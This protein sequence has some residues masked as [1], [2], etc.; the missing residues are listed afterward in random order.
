VTAL[1]FRKIPA[2][3]DPVEE[4]ESPQDGFVLDLSLIGVGA[5]IEALVG[6]SPVPQLPR[7]GDLEA[8]IEAALDHWSDD[9]WLSRS[10]LSHMAA[11]LRRDEGVD[12]VTALRDWLGAA[13]EGAGAAGEDDRLALRA[14][15]LSYLEPGVTNESAARRLSVSRATFYRLRKRGLSALAAA[16]VRPRA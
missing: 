11:F 15:Q 2:V 5:W 4:G 6:G 14:L 1:G 3:G 8:S 10:E 13:M 7:G 16:L 9:G 12:R